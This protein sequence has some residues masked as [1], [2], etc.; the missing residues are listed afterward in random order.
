MTTTNIAEVL[1]LAAKLVQNDNDEKTWLEFRF[2]LENYVTLVDE[3]YVAF[4]LETESQTVANLPAGT[5]EPAVTIRTLSHAVRL[6]GDTDHWT[7]LEAGVKSAEQEGSR[8]G[9]RWWPRT[10]RKQRVGD[11]RCCK[12]CYSLG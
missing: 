5:E 11:S 7:K 6:V 1:K 2:K 8:H 9:D 12:L 4:L 3:N 10:R